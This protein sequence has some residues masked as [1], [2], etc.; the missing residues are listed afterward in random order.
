[1]RGDVLIDDNAGGQGQELFIGKHLHF[2]SK[3]CPDWID[4]M[5]QLRKLSRGVGHE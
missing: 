4:A 2:G 1:M 5:E 3:Y